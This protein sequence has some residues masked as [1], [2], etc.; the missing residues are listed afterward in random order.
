MGKG[1]WSI[2]FRQYFWS[3]TF[4]GVLFEYDG[5]TGKGAHH[6]SCRDSRGPHN[7]ARSVIEVV[8]SSF[9][10]GY[11]VQAPSLAEGAIRNA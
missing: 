1:Q 3:M 9:R 6:V 11:M 7:C 8:V 2:K 10:K 4:W 5:C